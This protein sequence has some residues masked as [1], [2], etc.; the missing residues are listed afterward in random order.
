MTIKNM[1]TTKEKVEL[2]EQANLATEEVE[3][4]YSRDDRNDQVNIVKIKVIGV[5][6]KNG[7]EYKKPMINQYN[8]SYDC[9]VNFAFDSM[10][11]NM[12]KELWSKRIY[13]TDRS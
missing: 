7:D 10:M 5:F 13:I 11:K 9:W 4:E 2:L 6:K 1:F 12:L 3:V 8:S